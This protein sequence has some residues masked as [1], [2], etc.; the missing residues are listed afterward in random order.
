M[1]AREYLNQVHT[2][3]SRLESLMQSE[4]R[5]RKDTAGLK[6][7]DYDKDRVQTSVTNKFDDMMAEL[8]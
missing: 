4:Y 5:L 2:M 3:R 8:I 7:I 1:T 6:G